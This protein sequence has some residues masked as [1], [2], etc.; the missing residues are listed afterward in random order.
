MMHKSS[1]K[2]F[3]HWILMEMNFTINNNNYNKLNR[4]AIK[5]GIS[6]WI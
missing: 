4:Y 5:G 1:E 3:N 2:L 6:Q